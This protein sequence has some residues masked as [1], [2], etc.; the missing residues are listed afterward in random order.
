EQ[1]LDHPQRVSAG[2]RPARAGLAGRERR[3]VAGEVRIGQA[4]R[5]GTVKHPSNDLGTL[6]V[7]EGRLELGRA[8]SI[9][10]QV[11]RAL[12]T[13]RFARGLLSRDVKP[14]NIL[15]AGEGGVDPP[16]HVYLCYFG[17]STHTAEEGTLSDPGHFMGTIDYVAPEQ[18][19]GE[20][21]D[22][23]ADVYS[24]GC[25]LYES[26]TGQAPFRKDSK[27]AIFWAHLHEP[28]PSVTALRPDLPVEI[29]AVAASFPANSSRPRGAGWRR[30]IPTSRTSTRSTG[31]ATS[32]RG[33]RRGCSR[34]SSELPSV[35]CASR[36]DERRAR[37]CAPPR[38]EKP[39]HRKLRAGL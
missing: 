39:K 29:D 15:I 30:S 27:M 4:P 21:V 33:K 10:G 1:D 35:H 31:A 11:A 6:L 19:E 16:D 8:L 34:R 3:L 22:G 9:L 18:I 20:P 14:G 37:S 23:R 28:P 38:E 24:L 32:P 25:V 12:D 36:S 13:A 2:A 26:L 7:R 17:L 5:R